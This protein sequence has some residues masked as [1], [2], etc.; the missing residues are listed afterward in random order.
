VRGIHPHAHPVLSEHALNTYRVSPRPHYIP[1]KTKSRTRWNAS[2]P[3]SG[4]QSA[5]FFRGILS[6]LKNDFSLTTVIRFA[7][8]LTR[9][10]V[11]PSPIRWA[12][13]LFPGTFSRGCICF[14][15]LPRAIIFRPYGAP[16]G[17]RSGIGD[18][19]PVRCGHGDC[20]SQPGIV[21]TERGEDR[22]IN[23]QNFIHSEPGNR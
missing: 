3:D 11:P 12:R 14:A 4:V 19:F 23:A 18:L 9:H 10:F 15:V 8:A 17:L 22:E 6:S 16:T 7:A 1:D 20:A 5:K 21:V 13:G 2:L